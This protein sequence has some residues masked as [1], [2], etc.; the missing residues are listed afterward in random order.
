[1]TN[2]AWARFW[3]G[4]G[5][6]VVPRKSVEQKHPAVRWKNLQSRRVSLRELE[7]WKHLFEGGG[8]GTVTGA[9]S[10]TIVIETDGLSGEALLEEFQHAHGPLSS[11]LI[12]RSGSGRGN[13]YHFEH[14]GFWVPTKANPK[15]KI[16]VKGDGGFCILPPSLHTSGGRYTI[17]QDGRPA[18]LPQGLLQFITE[19]AARATQLAPPARRTGGVSTSGQPDSASAAWLGNNVERRLP[20]NRTNIGLVQLILDALPDHWARDYDKW[21]LVGF[22][23]QE[24]ASGQIGLALLK[25]FSSRC[26]GKA[27]TTDFDAH[28]ASLNSGYAGKKVTLG[29]LIQAAKQNGWEAP[30]RWDYSTL[31]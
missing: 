14:P 8:V 5:Y 21:L 29:T 10:Q 17:V 3:Y 9:I 1:M 28:W 12:I 30:C 4:R 6:N 20:V 11:T 31:S 16:D 7:C 18:E 2:V 19:A 25:R 27:G 13:H 23:L 24:F 26:A 15:I 22:A